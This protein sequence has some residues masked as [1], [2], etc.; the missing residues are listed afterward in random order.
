MGGGGLR[1]C[2]QA[3]RAIRTKSDLGAFSMHI[4]PGPSHHVRREST[5]HFG[6]DSAVCLAIKEQRLTDDRLQSVVGK[7][8]GNQE[9]RLGR[10]PS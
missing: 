6:F 7:W 10:R 3:K 2:R 8:F 9:S 1:T 5:V 4:L